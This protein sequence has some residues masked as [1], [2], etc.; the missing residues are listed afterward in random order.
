MT[1]TVN[2][3]GHSIGYLHDDYITNRGPSTKR[4]DAY[5]TLTRRYFPDIRVEEDGNNVAL[6]LPE[7]GFN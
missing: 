5:K 2:T 7:D 4:S 6:P 1:E 3:F